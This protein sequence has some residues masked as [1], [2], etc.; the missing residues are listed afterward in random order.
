MI[1]LYLHINTNIFYIF[2]TIAVDSVRLNKVLNF[3]PYPMYN[4]TSKKNLKNL[5][6]LCKVNLYFLL[7]QH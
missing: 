7:G 2:Y 4:K 1:L 6:R 5:K 3:P